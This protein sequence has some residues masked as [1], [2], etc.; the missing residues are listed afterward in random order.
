MRSLRQSVQPKF[1]R[2]LTLSQARRPSH[3]RGHVG[4]AVVLL[5]KALKG[6]TIHAVKR[7]EQVLEVVRSLN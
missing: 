4:S 5:G 1:T 3:H 6:L 2:L 7:I